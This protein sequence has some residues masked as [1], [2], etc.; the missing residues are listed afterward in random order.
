MKGRRFRSKC[1]LC[2][3]MSALNIGPVFAG[4]NAHKHVKDF[5]PDANGLV[6]VIEEVSI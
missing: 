2:T 6:A 1:L 5:H 4:W 3:W